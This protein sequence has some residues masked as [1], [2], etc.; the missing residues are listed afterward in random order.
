MG[1]H[2]FHTWLRT[3]YP[4]AILAPISNNIYEYIYIDVNFLMHTSMYGCKTEDD[5][6]WKLYDNF[7]RLFLNFIAT[8]KIFF[9]LDGVTPFAK[10]FLQRKRRQKTADNININKICSLYLTPGTE[11]MMRIETHLNEYITKLQKKYSFLNPELIISSSNNDNEGE[12]KICSDILKT[13]RTTK[14]LNERYLIVGGDAD[15]VVLSVAIKPIININV[16][17][18]TP[19]NKTELIS[20]KKLLE[21]HCE[22]LNI[23]KE[24]INIVR[25]DFVILSIMMGNDY[26]PKVGYIKFETLWSAYKKIYASNK[27][28]LIRNHTFNNNQFE[29]FML[30]VYNNLPNNFKKVNMNKYNNETIVSYLEGILWCWFM[31]KTG[32]PS[33]YDYY[34]NESGTLH[35]YEILYCLCNN[36]K[37]EIPKS[38]V[39][40]IPVH[41]FPL[42]L[43]PQ[44]AA[45]IIPEKYRKLMTTQLNYLYEEENCNI[46]KS[47]KTNLSTISKERYRTEDEKKIKEI[48]KNYGKELARMKDHRKSHTRTFNINDINK[49][50][51]LTKD[52]I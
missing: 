30:H 9:A 2:N 38:S 3:T 23:P 19:S 7:D 4:K 28:T 22:Y 6:I 17:V 11:T 16:L 35:P 43:L 40:S 52:L 45:A 24:R 32:V 48:N 37:L 47:L 20:I 36:K 44:K 29:K 39:K 50:I 33:K 46:C 8:K 5:F 51:E 12:I 13:Y 14:N 49:I 26:L 10:I 18:K 1:I 27:Q 42:L 25:D 21:Y 15:L 31:Y 41:I 34:Y